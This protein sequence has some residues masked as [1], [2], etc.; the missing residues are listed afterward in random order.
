M[1]PN[2]FQ[3]IRRAY[4]QLRPG[5]L[6]GIV[7]F[8]ISRK[9]PAAGMLKHSAFQRFFWPTWFGFDN[10]MLSPDHLPFLQSLFAAEHLEERKGK[11]PYLAGLQAPFYLFV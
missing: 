8:Y 5:G 4:D 9:W 3:A 1:I 2:W 11:V 6:I 7:D 10:V